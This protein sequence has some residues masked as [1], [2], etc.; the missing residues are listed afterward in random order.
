LH[1]A[2][3]AFVA[4]VAPNTPGAVLEIGSYY[5]NGGVRPL[6]ASATAYHGIDVRS[7]PG[8]DEA[9]DC[10]AYD[11]EQAFDVVVSTEVLEHMRD[12]EQMIACA[13]RSLKPGGLLVLTAAGPNRSAHGIDGGAIGDEYYRAI[14][15]DA[16]RWWLSGWVEVTIVE[17]AIACDLYA[18]AVK[19]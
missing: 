15:P 7:G 18:V 2:A 5:V 11:G 19:K 16:L 8:V 4:G 12:P 9:I 10:A 14:D 1:P 6:F 3:Y 17:N 13:W